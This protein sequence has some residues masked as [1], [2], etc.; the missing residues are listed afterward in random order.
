MNKKLSSLLIVRQAIL[1]FL[2]NARF[3]LDAGTVSRRLITRPFRLL[4]GGKINAVGL[5]YS[6]RATTGEQVIFSAIF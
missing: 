4:L 5:F 3:I 6:S 1:D 2:F